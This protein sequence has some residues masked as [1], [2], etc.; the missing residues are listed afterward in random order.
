MLHGLEIRWNIKTVYKINLTILGIKT[1]A[2][3]RVTMDT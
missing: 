1:G 3:A 2:T